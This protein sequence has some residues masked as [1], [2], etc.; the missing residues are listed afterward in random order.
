MLFLAKNLTN[1]DPLLKKFHN[2]TDDLKPWNSLIAPSSMNTLVSP[3]ESQL[4]RTKLNYV[5]EE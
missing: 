2:R 3:F 1:F 5:C 4:K